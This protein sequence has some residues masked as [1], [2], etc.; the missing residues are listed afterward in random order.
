MTTER[1]CPFR[2][3]SS[4]DP[5]AF[6]GL[7]AVIE[8]RDGRV[9]VGRVLRVGALAMVVRLLGTS[10]PRTLPR[11]LLRRCGLLPPHTS[12]DRAEAGRR[13]RARGHLGREPWPAP[14]R[15]ASILQLTPE[16]VAEGMRRVGVPHRRWGPRVTRRQ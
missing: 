12:H 16:L 10:E 14:Q 9:L 3:F 5:E 2:V 1:C 6:D 4:D 15:E 8:L 13:Q 7:E 11:E